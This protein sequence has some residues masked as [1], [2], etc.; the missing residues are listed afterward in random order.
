MERQTLLD[1]CGKFKEGD[2]IEILEQATHSDS[3]GNPTTTWVPYYFD[4][5]TNTYGPSRPGIRVSR[6]K[7]GS[8]QL[9]GRLSPPFIVK[10]MEKILDVRKGI[11]R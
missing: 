6:E 8:G 1:K 9:V 7:Y 11:V 3:L 10:E 2:L 5:I 4:G